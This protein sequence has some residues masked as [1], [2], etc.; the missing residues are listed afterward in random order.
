MM[1]TTVNTTNSNIFLNSHR[2]I[3]ANERKNNRNKDI[4]IPVKIVKKPWLFHSKSDK[5]MLPRKELH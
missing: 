5:P 4:L 3:D 1:N 2:N